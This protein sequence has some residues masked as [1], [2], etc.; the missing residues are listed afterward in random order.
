MKDHWAL[1]VMVGPP[2]SHSFGL[3]R[4]LGQ[5]ISNFPGMRAVLP[6]VSSVAAFLPQED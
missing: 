1:S 6:K 3:M 4:H 2:I 5:A